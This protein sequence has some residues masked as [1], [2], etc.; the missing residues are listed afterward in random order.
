MDILMTNHCSYRRRVFLKHEYV[1]ARFNTSNNTWT[2]GTA[3][4]VDET[5]NIVGEPGTGSFLQNVAFIDG[6]YTAGDDTPTNP[7]GT[8]RIFYSRINGAAAG[9]GLWSSLNTWSTD[10]VL[11]HTGAPATTVPGISDIVVIGARDSVYLAT[12]NTIANTD[13]RSCASLTDRKRISTGYRLQ[14][15]FKFWNGSYSSKRKW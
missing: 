6:D 14:L 7:F 13:P 15:Q 5:N 2:K 11:R 1:A 8:P 12:N 4:D 10:A 3:A 9:S